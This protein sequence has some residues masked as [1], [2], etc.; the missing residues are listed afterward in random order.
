MRKL[1]LL[2]VLLLLASPFFVLSAQET[3]GEEVSEQSDWF[4]D[5]QSQIYA[6]PVC[7]M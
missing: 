2:F 1:K 3:A 5:K 6:F 4:M 7:H